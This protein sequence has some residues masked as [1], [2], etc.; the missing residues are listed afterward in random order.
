MEDWLRTAADTLGVEAIDDD[1]Q[2]RLLGVARDVAHG[3]ERKLTPVAT[4]MLGEAV[5][6]RVAA[7]EDRAAAFSAAV[8]DLERAI[9]ADHDS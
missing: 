3:V 7:G 9:D 4:F 2:E 1:L 8:A 5:Q 6:R